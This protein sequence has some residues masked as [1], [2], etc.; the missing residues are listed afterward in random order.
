MGRK[1]GGGGKGGDGS[2]SGGVTL[3]W[4]RNNSLVNLSEFEPFLT[5][6]EPFVM[7]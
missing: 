5:S 7:R 6:S 3:R 4:Y 1:K 2:G